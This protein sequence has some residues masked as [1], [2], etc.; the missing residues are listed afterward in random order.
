M[1][2]EFGSHMLEGSKEMSERIKPDLLTF[3]QFHGCGAPMY[4]DNPDQAKAVVRSFL[5]RAT[6]G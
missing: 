1:A 5:R 4:K 6:P 3:Q 2:S